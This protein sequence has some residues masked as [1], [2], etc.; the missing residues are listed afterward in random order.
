[1]LAQAITEAFGCI[2]GFTSLCHHCDHVSRADCVVKR[3]VLLILLLSAAVSHSSEEGCRFSAADQKWIHS[4]YSIEREMTKDIFCIKVRHFFLIISLIISDNV[5]PQHEQMRSWGIGCFCQPWNMTEVSSLH[6]HSA[7][8]AVLLS[9]SF[10]CLVKRVSSFFSPLKIGRS[11]GCF[12]ISDVNTMHNKFWK[13]HNALAC[14]AVLPCT[15][16][17]KQITK[18]LMFLEGATHPESGS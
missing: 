1:M 11:S 12:H 8:V 6:L 5:A 10:T 13:Q 16:R 3:C 14:A 4:L 17:G 9:A 7:Q 18:K 2:R 15:Y